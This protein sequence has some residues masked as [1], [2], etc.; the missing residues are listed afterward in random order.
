M[1]SQ[2]TPKSVRLGDDE[3]ESGGESGRMW[4]VKKPGP[5]EKLFPHC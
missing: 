2:S 4:P 1:K 5:D 3:N